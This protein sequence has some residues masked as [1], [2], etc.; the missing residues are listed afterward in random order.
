MHPTKPCG[1]AVARFQRRAKIMIASLP[2]RDREKEGEK[3]DGME[4]YMVGNGN[5][6]ST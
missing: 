2:S 4:W 3:M 5:P 1:S 6:L